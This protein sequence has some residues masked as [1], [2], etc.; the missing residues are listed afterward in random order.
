MPQ[1]ATKP[2]IDEGFNYL[3]LRC[4]DCG[5]RCTS[6]YR[7]DVFDLPKEDSEDGVH[8][9]VQDCAVTVDRKMADN[10][11]RR[12]WGINVLLSCEGC[13]AIT[14]FSIA[15]HKGETQLRVEVIEESGKC[16]PITQGCDRPVSR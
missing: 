10:P 8:V 7:V 4:A 9:T 12:R 5:W 15:Q 2:S 6:H 3:V 14:K 11:S 13:S 1:A 16:G